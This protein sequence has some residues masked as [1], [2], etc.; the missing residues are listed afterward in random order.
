MK[1]SSQLVK[2]CWAADEMREAWEGD[3]ERGQKS[4][5]SGRD[6]GETKGGVAN[7]DTR[8]QGRSI[9]QEID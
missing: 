7:Y 8:N 1:S 2:S 6:T 4:V 9:K 5:E 3:V